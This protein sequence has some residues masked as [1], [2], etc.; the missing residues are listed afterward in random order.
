CYRKHGFPPNY[1]RTSS[2]NNASPDIVED[3]DDVVEHSGSKGNDSY[4]FTKEQYTQLLSLLQPSTATNQGSSS[5]HVNIASGHVASGISN[6]VCSL[7]SSSLD[8]WI[9]DSGASDHI[10][11]SLKCFSS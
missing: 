9:V 5:S 10:C 2:A 7:H 1:G 8:Q 6:L 11:S 3:R 4:S